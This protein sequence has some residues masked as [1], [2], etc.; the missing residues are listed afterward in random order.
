MY[1]LWLAMGKFAIALRSLTAAMK[2]Q[3]KFIPPHR[4]SRQQLGFQVM[5]IIRCRG[6]Q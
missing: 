5:Q 2:L 6:K 3:I 4:E 1:S